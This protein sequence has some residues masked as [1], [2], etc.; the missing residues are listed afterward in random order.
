MIILCSTHK[1][2]LSQCS[3]I[4]L[5]RELTLTHVYTPYHSNQFGK[6]SNSL[7]LPSNIQSSINISWLIINIYLLTS[8]LTVVYLALS[9]GKN[10]STVDQ[11]RLIPG[12]QYSYG[13][14]VDTWQ[15]CNIAARF[16][17]HNG[18]GRFKS[19]HCIMY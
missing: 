7:R 14:Q 18:H 11:T 17:K 16:K 12:S 13:R 2:Y 1:P 8:F 19:K 9:S 15:L 10:I 5:S 3:S 4:L 6:C